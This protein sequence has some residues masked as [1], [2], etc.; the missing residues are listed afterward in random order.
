[1]TVT[2]SDTVV[3]FPLEDLTTAVRERWHG[4]PNESGALAH[5]PIKWSLGRGT[6]EG[7]AW[8][9]GGCVCVWGVVVM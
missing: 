3:L 1:M 2:Y 4:R 8:W 6:G 9:Q 7:C 5:L